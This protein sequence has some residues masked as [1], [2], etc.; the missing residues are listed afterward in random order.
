VVKDEKI[1]DDHL[2]YIGYFSIKRIS[3]CLARLLS[4]SWLRVFWF[5][6]TPTPGMDNAPGFLLPRVLS[7]PRVI[8]DQIII[9]PHI[10]NGSR[11]TGRID[12]P[13]MV[14]KGPGFQ[15]IGDRAHNGLKIA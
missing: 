3:L 4:W 9:A 15:V 1:I 11:D 13:L 14:G 7:P 6:F 5:H 2:D 8:M 10:E 12:G